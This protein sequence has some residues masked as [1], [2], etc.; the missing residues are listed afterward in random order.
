ML[1]S[2]IN[3]DYD[4]R[5]QLSEKFKDDS[6][7]IFS[8]QLCYSII[9]LML[10]SFS[11]SFIFSSVLEEKS[12]KLVDML[13]ISV[14]LLALITGK[15]L[16]QMCYV[17][18]SLILCVSGYLISA[19]LTDAVT[20]ADISSQSIIGMFT[21]IKLSSGAVILIIAEILIAYL[22][23]SILTGIIA[24]SCSSMDEAGS[25][26][27]PIILI[28]VVAYSASFCVAIINNDTVSAVASVLPVISLFCAPIY[29]FTEN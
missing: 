9:I 13:L 10:I 2:R 3:F 22:T 6:E 7:S 26:S 23:F 18:V 12:T 14:R 1:N 28:G 29:Y 8:V 16:A 4:N 17:M 27:G 25:V 21:D 5:Q 24:S 20:G 19:K 11:V 15:I